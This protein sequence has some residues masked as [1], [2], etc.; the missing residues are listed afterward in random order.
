MPSPIIMYM[1]WR[2]GVDGSLIVS[3]R[4]CLVPGRR[5]RRS[6][7]KSREGQPVTRNSVW[8]LPRPRFDEA[9]VGCRLQPS[10]TPAFTALL[11]LWGLSPSDSL[12]NRWE[13]ILL[14]FVYGLCFSLKLASYYYLV[15]LVFIRRR[16]DCLKHWTFTTCSLFM[17]S[18]GPE[19][20]RGYVGD[21]GGASVTPEL[22]FEARAGMQFEARGGDD[23][24]SPR[25]RPVAT[26]TWTRKEKRSR[27]GRGGGAEEVSPLPMQCLRGGRCCRGASSSGEEAAAGRRQVGNHRVPSVRG[28]DAGGCRCHMPSM[29]QPRP[30]SG[31]NAGGCRDGAA[32]AAPLAGVAHAASCRQNPRK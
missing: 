11:H 13:F 19:I 1:T 8:L 26:L 21:G 32:I 10:S 20:H 15:F 12:Q 9:T 28:C 4:S 31:S 6:K 16:K 14:I 29:G 5:R 18:R 25:P 24:A 3:F 2:K 23:F 22:H 30:S 27:R 17:A 7:R